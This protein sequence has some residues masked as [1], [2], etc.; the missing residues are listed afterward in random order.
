MVEHSDIAGLL[1]KMGK[2]LGL[3]DGLPGRLVIQNMTPTGITAQLCDG[4]ASIEVRIQTR[5]IGASEFDAI[6]VRCRQS[7]SAGVFAAKVSGRPWVASGAK[8]LILANR[9]DFVSEPLNMEKCNG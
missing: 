1:A 2:T 9:V 6:Y 8:L 5:H 3:V 4:V 7:G